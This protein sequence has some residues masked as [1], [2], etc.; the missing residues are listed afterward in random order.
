MAT[1]SSSETANDLVQAGQNPPPLAAFL[2]SIQDGLVVLDGNWLCTYVNKAAAAFLKTTP[3]D[4]IGKTIWEV[5]PQSQHSHLRRRLTLVARQKASVR[6]EGYCAPRQRW[7]ECRCYP[8]DGG[9]TLFLVDITER[10]HTEEALKR[11]RTVLA[12]AGKMANLGV[13]SIEFTRSLDEINLCPLRWCD[14]VYR[15]FGYEPGSVEVTNDLF[16]RHVHPEDRQRVVNAVAQALADKQPYE[17]EHRILRPDGT[18]R[19]VLEHAEIEF[20]DQGRPLRM[21]GAV[22]DITGRKQMEAELRQWNDRLSEQVRSRTEQ[23]TATVC[24]LR[25]EIGRR[26]QAEGELGKSSQML[27]GFFEHTITPLVFMDKDFNFIRVNEAYAKADGREPES[28][29]GEN[30]FGLY[31]NE[32]NQAIFEQVVR[33]KQPYHA[34]AW[35][36]IYPHAPERGTTYWNWLLTP[37]LDERGDVQFLVFSLENVTERQKA[38]FELQ[39]RT[40]QLQHLAMELSQAEDRERK[41]LAELLHDDLQQLLAAAKF[42]LGLL[43]NHVKGEATALELIDEVKQVLV[44]AI[45]KSRSLSHEL[46]PPVLGQSDLCE[47]FEWMAEHVKAK[48]GLTVHLDALCP[49]YVESEPLKAFLYKA[50]QEMLFNVIKH[51][52]VK[53]AQLRLRRAN[54]RLWVCVSDKGR[55]FAPQEIEK[56]SGFGLLSVRERIELLGGRMRIKSAP[57]KGSVFVIS[58]PDPG[59]GKPGV[60][61]LEEAGE[62]ALPAPAVRRKRAKR[63]GDKRVRV[64][65]ADDHRVMR[66]GLAAMLDEEH[67]MEVVA[68]AGNGREAVDLAYQLAPDV[69]VMDV[70]MPVMPGDEA[71]RQIKRHLPNTRVIALSMFDDTHVSRRMQKAGADTYLSKSGPSEELLAAIRG[72]L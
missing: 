46:S 17:I 30:C 27:E 64:L 4:C 59:V 7:Y 10:K 2:E 69:V 12:Q 28:F 57:G 60:E 19:I 9:L 22:Q 58:V 31:P 6:F 56:T 41:H 70:A 72:N 25:D 23:L 68:Q 66:E 33:T 61:P 20:D 36:F 1:Q 53:E 14:Q 45:G 47:I 8:I 67:D 13:W 71:T 65:L 55:G 50:I 48:H 15:I 35:P 43:G 29:V 3:D 37:L 32:E 49:I 21:I 34:Y 62:A 38:F 16:F 11:S 52:K 40:R 24:H 51:A 39:Q 26:V 42:Q 63:A 5:F 18:E 54:G 44:E